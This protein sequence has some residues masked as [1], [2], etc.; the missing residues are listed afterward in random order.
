MIIPWAIVINDILNEEW[1][2]IPGYEGLYQVSDTGK[3]K[4]VIRRGSFVAGRKKRLSRHVTG[5]QYVSL[6]ARDGSEKKHYIQR[7][8]MMSFE[9]ID[10]A[11]H[12][13]V[14]HV[15]GNKLN[16][17]IGN[18]EWLS[19]RDNIIHARTVLKAWPDMRGERSANAKLTDDDVRTIRALHLS[20]LKQK[21]IAARYNVSQPTIGYIVHGKTWG[22]VGTADP[23]LS[24]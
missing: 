1:R 21:D 3:I 4:S 8:V 19:H 23:V 20:G 11:E 5:Y 24:N 22:H 10:S 16:N 9:P 6:T 12:L 13:D 2:D 15:D 7:L 18:L 17:S 14:N